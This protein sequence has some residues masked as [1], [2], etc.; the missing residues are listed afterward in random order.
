[1]AELGKRLDIDIEEVLSSPKLK[2]QL[3]PAELDSSLL[4][5]YEVV[6]DSP[7]GDLLR[8][9]GGG[10]A[11]ALQNLYLRRQAERDHMKYGW[12]PDVFPSLVDEVDDD[13]E[14][15]PLKRIRAAMRKNL[16]HNKGSRSP[17]SATSSIRK[18]MS[19][20]SRQGKDTSL[21]M[22]PQRSMNYQPPDHL[23]QL[24]WGHRPPALS[25]L[26]RPGGLTMKF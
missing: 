10:G 26:P 24:I 14:S 5:L 9:I 18:P 17:F 20:S 7:G 23:P 3:S 16:P 1:V 6:S 4:E 13:K 19:S 25:R 12:L 11:L 8:L 2:F 22:F 21:K 15:G